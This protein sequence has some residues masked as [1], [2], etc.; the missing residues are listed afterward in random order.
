MKPE[1]HPERAGVI[2]T[3]LHASV[4]AVLT[5]DQLSI[6]CEQE[7]Q[8]VSRV[9]RGGHLTHSPEFFAV[10]QLLRVRGKLHWAQCGGVT[11]GHT[12]GE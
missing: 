8:D 9:D 2:N 10:H 4:G 12:V 6:L 11:R 1:E 3:G 7:A 5:Q